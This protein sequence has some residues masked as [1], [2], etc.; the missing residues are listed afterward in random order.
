MEDLEIEEE[1]VEK[2]NQKK[3]K[4]EEDVNEI[5]KNKDFGGNIYYS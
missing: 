2:D 3:N 1:I 4:E 5:K